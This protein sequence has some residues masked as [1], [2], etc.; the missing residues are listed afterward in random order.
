MKYGALLFL[1]VPTQA[2]AW[3]FEE[4]TICRLT[5][6]EQAASVD[7]TFDPA[8]SRY[9]ITLTRPVPWPNAPIFQLRFDGPRPFA[10]S[11]DRHTLSENGT[12]LTVTDT[13][14]GNVLDGIQYNAQ[15]TAIVGDE[16]TSVSTMTAPEPMQAFRECPS[17]PT[18]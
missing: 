11:T 18:S 16:T 5:H 2:T 14:F 17:A 9:S 12:R 13:G 7:L 4:T 8:A 6:T 3:E 15:M 1:L 10:I